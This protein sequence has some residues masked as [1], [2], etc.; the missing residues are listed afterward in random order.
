MNDLTWLTEP[1]DDYWPL[2]EPHT[3]ALDGEERASLVRD[4]LTANAIDRATIRAE[5]KARRSGTELRTATE[6]WNDLDPILEAELASDEFR[7]A[8]AYIHVSR[9]RF[10]GP[11]YSLEE[12]DEELDR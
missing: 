3:A 10:P 12:L 4:A 8:A 6:Q 2:I 9:Q 1:H 5:R 7:N 11:R